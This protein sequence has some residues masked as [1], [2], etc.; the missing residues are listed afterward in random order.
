M[1]CPP[2]HKTPACA[3]W[4]ARDRSPTDKAQREAERCPITWRA[5][6]RFM[7]PSR[8]AFVAERENKARYVSSLQPAR[9]FA[10]RLT[11]QA[12]SPAASRELSLRTLRSVNA[13]VA[14]LSFHL[15]KRE[16]IRALL[17]N[18]LCLAMCRRLIL[19]SS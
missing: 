17:E 8:R 3:L 9:C 2:D 13:A 12:P 16:K 10:T 6:K 15:E 14:Q 4:E 18:R 19:P 7:G 5:P 11:C 1:E